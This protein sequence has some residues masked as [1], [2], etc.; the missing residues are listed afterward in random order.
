MV[1]PNGKNVKRLDNPQGS[2]LINLLKEEPSETKWK[3][4]NS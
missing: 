3:W 4:S 1:E 2:F